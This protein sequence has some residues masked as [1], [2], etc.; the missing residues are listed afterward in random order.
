MNKKTIPSLTSLNNLDTPNKANTL[1]PNTKRTSFKLPS[2]IRSRTNS[3]GNQALQLENSLQK[4]VKGTGA[5]GQYDAQKLKSSVLSV[6]RN[7]RSRYS[8]DFDQQKG[9]RFTPQDNVSACK[10]FMIEK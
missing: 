5:A 10:I 9:N 8:K 3:K 1:H 6:L 4:N 2:D 7:R